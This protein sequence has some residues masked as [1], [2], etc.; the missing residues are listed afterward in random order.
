MS[1]KIIKSSISVSLDHITSMIY[2]VRHMAEVILKRHIS[3]SISI[4]MND[5]I[6]TTGELMLTLEQFKISDWADRYL[7]LTSLH[8]ILTKIYT[9]LIDLNSTRIDDKSTDLVSIDTLS[10][11]LQCIRSTIV[12]TSFDSIDPSTVEELTRSIPHEEKRE[13]SV[14]IK[15]VAQQRDGYNSVSSILDEDNI[16]KNDDIVLGICRRCIN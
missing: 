5:I 16:M 4:A 13:K 9:T 8:H 2:L 14:E 3:H 1:T 6:N 12:D 15:Y 11:N 7:T 10:H